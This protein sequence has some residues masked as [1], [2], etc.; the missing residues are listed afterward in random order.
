MDLSHHTASL[1]WNV[2]SERVGAFVDAWDAGGDPPRLAE[3][4]PDGAPEL[5][6]LTLIELIKVDLSYRWSRPTERMLLEDY[7]ADFPELAENGEMPCDLIYE[8]FYVRKQ[9][10]AAVDLGGYCE[11]FPRQAVELKRLLGVGEMARHSTA[12]VRTKPLAPIEAG[13]SIDDFDLLVHLGKGA[14]ANVF[15]ARQRS[16]QRLV[17]LK[18]SAD[19]GNEPQTMAQLDH[20]HI[21]RVYDQRLLPERNVRLLYMQ[22]VSGGTLQAVAAEVRETSAALR[23]GKLLLRA[24]DAAL[25][26]RGESPPADSS[27]R[28]RVAEWSWP[29]V[30]CWLG[31]RLAAALDYAHGRGVLH[32]DLKPANVLITAD[33]SPKL[34][35]FNISF[36]SKVEGATPAAY[37]GG[38]LAYMSPEQLE[39][40]NPN[41][42]RTAEELDG[43]ADIYSLGVVLW[44]L[45][46][47]ARPFEEEHLGAIWSRTLDEMTARR[48]AGVPPEAIA[49]L[50][51]GMP[52]GM[53]EVLLKCLAPREEGRF[54][55]AGELARQLELCLQPN[56]Q[57]LLRPEPQDWTLVARRLALPALVLAGVIPNAAASVMNIAYNRWQIIGKLEPAAY[58]VFIRQVFVVNPIAYLAA[59]ILLLSLAMPIVRSVRARAFGQAIGAEELFKARRRALSIGDWV[60]WVS[61]I[62]WTLSGVVFPL[63]LRLATVPVKEP[64]YLH[65]LISQ[66]LCG[67]IAASLSFFVVSFLSARAFYPALVDPQDRDPE[68]LARLRGL[69]QRTGVYFV[70]TVAAY[71]LSTFAVLWLANSTDDQIAIGVLGVI[72]FPTFILAY[73]LSSAIR[74][75]LETLAIVALPP[76]DGPGFSSEL[77]DSSWSISRL[78]S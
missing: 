61:A 40:F 67:L 68:A 36:S 22:Y 70:L 77:S 62:E 24:I 59:I 6:R 55:T 2:V 13:E 37:F 54:Q 60:A 65:F 27:W 10:G 30:V 5:R 58:D 78:R 75:D 42:P 8:E 21:V 33:G 26:S 64:Y 34:A 15:L 16:M 57:R 50:P 17:A 74:R 12:L 32:R 72:G 73:W 71:F 48:R 18:V 69:A 1:A 76:H 20:P 3:F 4:L 31:A 66:A 51:I 53:Q 47:G 28:R 56:V 46:T 41:H 7:L 35:D 29:A 23:S 49:R 43:R 14:F 25:Y 19:Q 39:A 63:W 9:A 44:E 38:S 11:R 45:L 52:Q